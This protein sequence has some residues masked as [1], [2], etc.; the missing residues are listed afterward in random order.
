MISPTNL[1]LS[2]KTQQGWAHRRRMLK[3]NGLLL[4]KIGLY[5]HLRRELYLVITSLRSLELSE[6]NLTVSA[7]LVRLTLFLWKSQSKQVY[8][9]PDGKWSPP[10]VT[11]CNT[12]GITGALPAFNVEIKTIF[13]GTHAASAW[14]H[15]RV[16][17][18]HRRPFQ[19]CVEVPTTPHSSGVL[20]SRWCGWYLSMWRTVIENSAAGNSSSENSPW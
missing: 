2:F 15:C 8:G 13:K 7:C 4:N 11:L 17:V 19:S 12:S 16:N 3:R 6:F 5:F 10:P 20:I 1:E 9:S 18:K 14:K